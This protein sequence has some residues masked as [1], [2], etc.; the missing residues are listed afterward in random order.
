[1]FN[2]FLDQNICRYELILSKK[3]KR[4]RRNLNLWNEVSL[5]EEIESGDKGVGSGN[6]SRGGSGVVKEVS[7]GA[8]DA[9]R[10]V[11]RA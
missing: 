1:L 4:R 5:G 6:E 7:G 8:W 3:K 2:L 11:G 10:R 9:R